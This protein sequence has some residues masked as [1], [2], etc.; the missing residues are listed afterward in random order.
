MVSIQ[1]FI[2]TTASEFVVVVK[3]DMLF[4]NKIPKLA[5]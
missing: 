2:K 3:H 1:M 4:L 5:L